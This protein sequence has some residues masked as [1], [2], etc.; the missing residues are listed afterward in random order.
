M[1][2]HL[3]LILYSLFLCSGHAITS[4]ITVK[5]VQTEET[6]DTNPLDDAD[7]E[8]IQVMSEFTLTNQFGS[9]P[10]LQ[11]LDLDQINYDPYIPM[12]TTELKERP[13]VCDYCEKRFKRISHRTRHVETKHSVAMNFAC[14]LCHKRMNRADNVIQHVRKV[15]NQILQDDR[16]TSVDQY[17]IKI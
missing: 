1:R 11:E 5:K 10:P 4:E 15:H 16:H 2:L 3:F 14:L 12:S 9:L 17:V 7:K 13:Y 8:W 6:Q